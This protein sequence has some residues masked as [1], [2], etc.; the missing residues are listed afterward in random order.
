MATELEQ[1]GDYARAMATWVDPRD[2]ATRRSAWCRPDYPF[3]INLPD[4]ERCN[5]YIG[6]LERFQARP[7]LCACTCHPRAVVSDA[8]AALWAR[9]ADEIDAH[10]N[11]SDQDPPLFEEPA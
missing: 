9:L 4:H 10:L 6:A 8:D 5:G 3:A 7:K 1:F 2:R 11:A